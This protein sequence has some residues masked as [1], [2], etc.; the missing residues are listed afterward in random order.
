MPEPYEVLNARVKQKIAT[1]DEWLAIDTEFGVIFEGESAFVKTAEGLPV[2][3]KLGDGTKKFS[4]LPYFIAYYSNVT[5]QKVLPYENQSANIT[6]TSIF[7]NKSLI[8]DI[9]FV[10]NAGSS[11]TINIGTTDGGSEIAEMELSTG[12]TVIGLKKYFTANT[13]IYLTGLDGADFSIYVLYIQ[14]D[15]A[16]VIP[17]SGGGGISSAY[18]YGTVYSFKPM[19]EG[20][21]D[22][23][24]DLITGLGKAGT[25]YENCVLFGTNDTPDLAGKYLIGYA[26]GNTLGGNVGSNTIKLS[27]GQLPKFQV[28][29]FST[30]TSALAGSV[31]GPNDL[32]ARY[33]GHSSQALDYE[34]TKSPLGISGG[35]V[36][37]SGPVG[38]TDDI[39]I[40]PNSNIVLYFTGPV[41]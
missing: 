40:K 36:G 15:E 27:I 25:P 5:N 13:T 11:V 23:V 34:I 41:S 35:F 12:P 29:L 7:R 31:P 39:T 10:N 38:N 19:Y 21:T 8:T 22:A 16:P 18:V 9:I 20:H 30:G 1:E 2:N 33:R 28:P 24:W 37:L 4:E 3:F 32:V 17:P 14:T 26:N 6:I